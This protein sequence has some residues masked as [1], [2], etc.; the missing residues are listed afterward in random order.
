MSKS[1]NLALTPIEVLSFPNSSSVSSV[2]NSFR[3]Q[4]HPSSLRSGSR[5]RVLIYA[6]CARR[7]SLQVVQELGRG[8]TARYQ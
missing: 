7:L 2:V 5:R 4:A 1:I 3:K 8:V 6:G